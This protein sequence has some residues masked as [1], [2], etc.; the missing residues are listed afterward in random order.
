MG[1]TLYPA[2]RDGWPEEPRL[3]PLG[4]VAE[5]PDRPQGFSPAICA[6]YLKLGMTEPAR[7]KTPTSR[8]LAIFS[9]T[10]WSSIAHPERLTRRHEGVTVKRTLAICALIGAVLVPSVL[11]ADPT[12]ADFKNAAK[13]CKAVRES[14]GVEAFNAQYGTN[15]N[16]KNA[17]GKCVSATNKA[18]AKAAKR[19]REGRRR[20]RGEGNSCLQEAAVRERDP[21]SRR[22]TNFGPVRVGEGK[23]STN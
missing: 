7:A 11:A 18:K 21:S 22:T 10:T 2:S 6:D 17:Y 16:K 5:Q 3:Q 8:G 12:P 9:L 20:G 19:R 4:L 15:K 13:Y 14:K 1:T 23:S